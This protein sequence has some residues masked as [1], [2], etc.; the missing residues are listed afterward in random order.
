MVLGLDVPEQQHWFQVDLLHVIDG[1]LDVTRGTGVYS[2][3]KHHKCYTVG[4]SIMEGSSHVEVE[5]GGSMQGLSCPKFCIGSEWHNHIFH[6]H[7]S[8]SN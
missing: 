6:I 3:H 1:R 8:L 5:V 2:S 4:Q 7:W